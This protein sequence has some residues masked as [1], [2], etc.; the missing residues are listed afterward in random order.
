[1]GMAPDHLFDLVTELWQ[2][3]QAHKQP[4]RYGALSMFECRQT[5]IEAAEAV[6]G[7]ARLPILILQ[8]QT[9]SLPSAPT[10]STPGSR[11]YLTPGVWSHA[12]W[13]TGTAGIPGVV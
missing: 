8:K 1:M 9:W 7:E 10:S 3:Q 2:R 4:V 5:L 12:P 11:R 6:Y 13:T